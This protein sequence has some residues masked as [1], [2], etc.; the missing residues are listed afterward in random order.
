LQLQNREG[1]RGVGVQTSNA[2]LLS[3]DIVMQISTPSVIA[4]NIRLESRSDRCV[5]GVPDIQIGRPGSGAATLF[6]GDFYACC[7][8]PRSRNSSN[9]KHN[10]NKYINN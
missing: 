10:T 8:K 9:S 2:E 4:R 5:C 3:I 1:V 6:I 7:P